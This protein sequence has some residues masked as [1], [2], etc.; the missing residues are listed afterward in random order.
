MLKLSKTYR[1]PKIN[2][3]K[4]YVKKEECLCQDLQGIPETFS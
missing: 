1:I 4:N 2:E 3:K